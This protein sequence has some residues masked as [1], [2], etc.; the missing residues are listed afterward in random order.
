MGGQEWMGMDGQ[1][2]LPAQMPLFMRDLGGHGQNTLPAQMPLFM[3]DLG[4]QA[5]HPLKGV[6][7]VP[8]HPPL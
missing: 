8:A 3:R 7:R 5:N 6:G 2:T 4:G 1:N